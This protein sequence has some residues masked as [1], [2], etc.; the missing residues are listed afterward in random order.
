MVFAKRHILLISHGPFE[1]YY[2]DLL[3]DKVMQVF[4]YPVMISECNH[5]LN[6]FYVPERRQYDANKILH[7]LTEL[8]KTSAI[9]TI[10]LLRVD[11][12]IPILTYIFGQALFKGDKGVVSIFR[13]RNEQY[14][15][16]PHE[17]LLIK[18]MIKV[19]IHE[20]GHTFGLVHCVNPDCVMRGNTYVEEID[21]QPYDPCIRC[22]EI[23]RSKA[24]QDSA[25]E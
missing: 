10:A 5:D 7:Y 8:P 23:I 4:E 25:S 21:Q 13:L 2:L 1:K 20:L 22:Q 19:V 24:D 11:L 18:R 12:F 15:L 16:E 3:A 9:K 17:E 14:G 6:E